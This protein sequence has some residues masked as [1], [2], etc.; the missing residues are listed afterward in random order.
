MTELL[1]ASL[2]AVWQRNSSID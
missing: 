2:D 1:K